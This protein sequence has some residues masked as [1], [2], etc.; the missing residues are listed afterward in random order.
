MIPKTEEER[1]LREK[2][3]KKIAGVD[4]AGRGCL[5]GPIVASACILPSKRIY[6]LRD[7]KTL[8][9]KEREK[10]S[11]KIK[12]EARAYS[13][14]K[15]SNKEIDFLGLQ[16]AGLL[17]LRRAVLNLK[18]RPDFVL[19]DFYKIP[20]LLI[21]QKSI[22]KGDSTC[23]SISAASI[24]AKVKR[25]NLMK[26]YAKKYPGYGFEKHKGYGTKE[27]RKALKRLGPCQIHRQ[28]FAPIKNFQ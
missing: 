28:G 20:H 15:V 21:P 13:F 22:K 6:K 25:D 18:P 24:L 5:A 1:R 3:F 9:Q 11:Q 2:G 27:H 26:K 12:K 4:E 8:S 14:G 19:V 10:L 17:A 16:K 7:S 23:L